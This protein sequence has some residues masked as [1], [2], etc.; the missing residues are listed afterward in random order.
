MAGVPI[1]ATTA[2][3]NPEMVVDGQTGLLARVGDLAGLAAAIRRLLRQ[4]ELVALLVA[5][6]GARAR[7]EC[8]QDRYRL[9]LLGFYAEALG[10]AGA[11]AEYRAPVGA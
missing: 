11:A 4:Q 6:A 5:A 9:L 3:G 1:V 8:S 7:H 10:T 2:G